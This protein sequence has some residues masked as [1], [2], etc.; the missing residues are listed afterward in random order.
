[1]I[2]D[3]RRVT[4]G[5]HL[6]QEKAITFPTDAKLMHKARQRLVRLA[7]AHAVPLRQSYV[8]ASASGL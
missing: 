6:V 8:Q 4:R 1:M 2:K 3:L 7:K 5:Y